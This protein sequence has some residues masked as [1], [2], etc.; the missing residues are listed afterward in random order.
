MLEL[1]GLHLLVGAL[2]SEILLLNDILANKPT[3]L[4]II[5]VRPHLQA[6]LQAHDIGPDSSF[7]P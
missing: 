3:F 2:L 1:K 4:G 6:G 7:L 5:L